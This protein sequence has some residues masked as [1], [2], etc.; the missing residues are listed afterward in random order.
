MEKITNLELGFRDEVKYEIEF[1]K[2]NTEYYDDIDIEKIG[3]LTDED[4]NEIA[5]D[6]LY[7]E[8]LSERINNIIE[9]KIRN[10]IGVD[11]L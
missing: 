7:D 10:R 6:L 9:N 4:I 3:N 1:M 11:Y 8:V 2:N 5:R